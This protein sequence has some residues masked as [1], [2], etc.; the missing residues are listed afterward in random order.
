MPHT[1]FLGYLGQSLPYGYTVAIKNLIIACEPITLTAL[2]PLSFFGEGPG[3]RPIVDHR[4]FHSAI[5][6]QGVWGKLFMLWECWMP[7][8]KEFYYKF[9]MS[10]PEHRGTTRMSKSTCPTSPIPIG[11]IAESDTSQWGFPYPN[12]YHCP[13][14]PIWGINGAFYFSPS[15]W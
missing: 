7:S 9:R 5:V 8:K 3:V 1:H 13:K 4:F 15:C 2:S 14:Y 6:T 10:L 11:L 12:F